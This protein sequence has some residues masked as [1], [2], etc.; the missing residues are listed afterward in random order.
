MLKVKDEVYC[1]DFLNLADYLKHGGDLPTIRTTIIKAVTSN[2]FER[3]PVDDMLTV[4][5][6]NLGEIL[7]VNQPEVNNEKLQ[8]QVPGAV[9]LSWD[10][11]AQKYF[12]VFPKATVVY[13]VS[14][15]E[16][17]FSI[18][19]AYVAKTKEELVE[20][21]QKGLLKNLDFTHTRISLHPPVEFCD[22]DVDQAMFSK[23]Q[24]P[25]PGSSATVKFTA[26]GERSEAVMYLEK[27]TLDE[28]NITLALCND[29]MGLYSYDV[30]EVITANISISRNSVTAGICAAFSDPTIRKEIFVDEY[31]EDILSDDYVRERI[32]EGIQKLVWAREEAKDV[33]IEFPQKKTLDLC[34]AFK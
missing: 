16:S 4:R 9:M 10:Y 21:V 23:L 28:S 30:G 7:S 27:I 17:D 24:L 29:E 31:A 25:D 18:Y 11:G 22:I 20:R 33:S 19:A 6:N 14:D 3:I 26:K 5:T 12:A 32:P 34:N 15:I 13:Y 1:I 2:G 8:Q